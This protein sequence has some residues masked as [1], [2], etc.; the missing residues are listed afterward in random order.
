MTRRIAS[1]TLVAVVSAVIATAPALA[2]RGGGGGSG[3]ATIG[4]A[5]STSAPARFGVG[6][7]LSFAVT[8]N[9]KPADVYSL[10][11]ANTCSQNGVVVSTQYAP[12]QDWLAG[13]FTLSWTGGSATCTAYV[14][15]F[16]D[17]WTPL[18][19][20]LMSYSVAG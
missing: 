5:P 7:Q 16:P 9:V 6:S 14:A 3:T 18:R 1:A 20:G 2:A 12:V 8:A 17:V 13:P 15:L 4:F 11:V 10:W 19:G